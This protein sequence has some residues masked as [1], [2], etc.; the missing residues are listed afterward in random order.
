MG[1]DAEDAECTLQKSATGGDG[2]GGGVYVSVQD[3]F[4]RNTI[5]GGKISWEVVLCLWANG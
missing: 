5:Q 2:G 4:E 1:V 3:G